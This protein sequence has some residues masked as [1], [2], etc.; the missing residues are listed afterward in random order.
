MWVLCLVLIDLGSAYD[1]NLH[2]ECSALGT[3]I[4]EIV[5]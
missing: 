1:V 5:L 4:S 2:R 3:R